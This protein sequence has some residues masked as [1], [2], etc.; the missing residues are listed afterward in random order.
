MIDCGRI[1]RAVMALG[2]M[3]ALAA[4]S[5]IPKGPG[6]GAPPPVQSTSIP[7]PTDTGRHRVALLVPMSGPS[8]VAG[9][10]LANATTMALLDTN[11]TNLRIT[12]YDT[13][14]GAPAAAARAIADGNRL[15]LGPLVGDDA[16]AVAQTARGA[17]VP[18]ISYANDAGVAGENI[19]V[20]GTI[21]AQSIARVVKYARAQGITHFAAL[22]PVGSYGERVS[23]A[24]ITAVRASGGTLVGMES[25]DHS[26]GALTSAVRRLKG[27][28]AFEAVLIGDNASVA[29]RAAPLLKIGNPGLHIIGPEL[30][31]GEAAIA[32]TPALA[33]AWYAALSDQRFSR[34][35]DSYKNRFGTPPY[36]IAT[37]GYDSV[38]LTLRVAREWQPGAAFPTARLYDK[39]GFLGLD[40][41]FRF[42][43][44][45][46][47]ERALEV[48]E[49]RG[50]AITVVSPAPA[51]FED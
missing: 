42:G 46:V 18:V 6:E 9:Q 40:G 14:P 23:N 8:G 21:P 2:T 48:R 24:M 39:G 30:W 36:R 27:H 28:G 17:H 3:A 51:R 29:V 44:S 10:S 22:T 35:S 7:L 50:G 5:V 26:K 31:N 49:A 41:I 45:D 1:S 20:M 47:I 11:A 16:V 15:I 34:F 19:F 12:T 43:S 37:L 33:G 25:Y 38:L 13:T 4:C 32:H